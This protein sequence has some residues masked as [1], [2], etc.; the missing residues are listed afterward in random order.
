MGKE[1]L[2]GELVGSAD[3]LLLNEGCCDGSELGRVEIEGESLGCTVGGELLEGAS[4]GSDDG[5]WLKDGANEGSDDGIV[6]RDGDPVGW[7]VG[8]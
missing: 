1:L 6:E 4:V 7:F 2:D 5:L 8:R 3:G